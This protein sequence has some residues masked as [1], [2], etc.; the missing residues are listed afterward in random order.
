MVRRGWLSG[1]QV[2]WRFVTTVTWAPAVT[3]LWA[4]R[5]AGVGAPRRP[6]RTGFRRT[7][8]SRI[9]VPRRSKPSCT[10]ATG[11]S[12]FIGAPVLSHPPGSGLRRRTAM[13]RRGRHAVASRSPSRW[14]G[15]LGGPLLLFCG[16]LPLAALWLCRRLLLRCMRCPLRLRQLLVV[17]AASWTRSLSGCSG[18]LVWLSMRLGGYPLLRG[19]LPE[20]TLW[21][22][23]HCS[24][25]LPTCFGRS[26]GLG[27][28]PGPLR[29]PIG[30]LR[31]RRLVHAPL[32]WPTLVRDA[33][34]STRD[35]SSLCTAPPGLGLRLALMDH[36]RRTTQGPP[37]AGTKERRCRSPMPP[38]SLGRLLPLR[39]AVR[40]GSAR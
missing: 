2:G 6:R 31:L 19:R 7:M 30:R 23:L 36:S 38:R 39:R 16:L 1:F 35:G 25:G 24:V 34:L 40:F 22:A 29:G 9:S 13:W 18:P 10:P 32:S 28:G 37:A 33:G 8:G 27:G 4:S 5:R 3:N 17:G 15:F 20:R 21:T 26:G 14:Q 11:T 12:R